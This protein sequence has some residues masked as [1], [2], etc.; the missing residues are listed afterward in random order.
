MDPENPLPLKISLFYKMRTAGK[1]LWFPNA[2]NFSCWGVFT[3]VL[4]LRLSGLQDWSGVVSNLH[5]ALGDF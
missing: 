4:S 1:D 2:G 5:Q 3:N